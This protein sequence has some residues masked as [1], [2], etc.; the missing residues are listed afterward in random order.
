MKKLVLI[1]AS[2]L[3]ISVAG[4]QSLEDI[5]SKYSSAI[6]A[7]QLAKVSTIMITGKMS[8]MGMEMPMTMFM[9][10]PNKIKVVYSINGQEIVSAFDGE[11]GYMINPITGSSNPVELTGAQLQ[12]VQ[13]SNVFS[14]EI[15]NYFRNGKLVLE[16]EENVNGK[17]AFKV[18][19]SP[20]GTTPVYMFI[21]KDSF[22][23]VKTTARVEQMGT[24]MDVESVMTDYVENNGVVMPKKTTASANG[25]EAA[26]IT[27]DKI[28]VN[29]PIEDTVFKMK[30]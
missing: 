6:K 7:D 10:N 16:G 3:V 15:L 1:F 8:T 9:K 27:F 13:N 25:M 19:A 23:L 24:T 5:V 29:V 17:P 28:E 30:K 21:D 20:D 11:K 14:N 26:V 4:A 22:L 2:L 12:Q 18:K